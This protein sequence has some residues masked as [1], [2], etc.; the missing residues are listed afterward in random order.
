M[1]A[2]CFAKRTGSPEVSIEAQIRNISAAFSPGI[3]HNKASLG[4]ASCALSVHGA[5]VSELLCLQEE[6]RKRSFP[7]MYL[8]TESLNLFLEIDENRHQ[9]YDP[10]CELARLDTLQY[11]VLEAD[12]KTLVLI[13]FNPHNVYTDGVKQALPDPDDR[14]KTLIHTVRNE[15]RV[16]MTAEIPVMTV[17]YLF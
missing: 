12:L 5:Q 13:R 4:G 10:A 3:E 2:T 15:M 7:D 17:K 9:Y 14:L 11:G 16:P 6:V 1:C 8:A